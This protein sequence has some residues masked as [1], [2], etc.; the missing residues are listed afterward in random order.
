ME[1]RICYSDYR[2]DSG[3]VK[4]VLPSQ[5]T[6]VLCRQGEALLLRVLSRRTRVHSLI[7][8]LF[9]LVRGPAQLN[10][11]AAV[12][13]TRNPRIELETILRNAK[14]QGIYRGVA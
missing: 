13:G 3:R 4:L 12:F 10:L 5:S 8:R 11:F 2:E 6:L 7:V 14:V 1:V 9:D